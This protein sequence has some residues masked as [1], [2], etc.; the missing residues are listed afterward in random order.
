MKNTLLFILFILSVVCSPLSASE[1]EDYKN[2]SQLP[3]KE[4]YQKGIEM[5]NSQTDTALK[6]F[7]LAANKYSATLSSA[8]KFFCAQAYLKMGELHLDSYNFQ[9]AFENALKGVK[10]CEDNKIENLLP[11]FY[12]IIGNIYGIQRDFDLSIR[13]YKQGLELARKYK[14]QEVE[15]RLLSNLSLSYTN[16]ENLETARHYQHLLESHPYRDSLTL[17]FIDFNNAFIHAIEG[18]Y[19]NAIAEFKTNLQ[20]STQRKL[21]PH[22]IA[23]LYGNIAQIYQLINQ[24]DSALH[25]MLLCEQFTRQH[26]L[27]NF[28]KDILRM[29]S[30]FYKQ[31]NNLKKANEYY[32]HY[33][34]LADSVENN[35]QYKQLKN[36]QIIYELD[37]NSQQINQ[38]A[39]EK[40]E[41]EQ[42]V[43]RQRRMIL[44]IGLGLIVAI[45]ITLIIYKQKKKLQATYL[46]LYKRNNAMIQS[47]I[48]LESFTDT[49]AESHSEESDEVPETS[50]VDEPSESNDTSRLK[51]DDQQRKELLAQIKHIMEETT[52]YCDC[53]FSLEKL[54]S[55]IG[56]NSKYVSQLINETYGK[57]FRTFINEYRIK[58]ACLRLDNTEEYGNYTVQAIGE[59]VGYKS[60][61]NFTEIFKKHTGLTPAIYQKIAKSENGKNAI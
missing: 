3:I 11:Q 26:R 48:P 50:Q 43:V 47:E 49:P 38:L 57:N 31:Q 21:A 34:Q 40:Q 24:P 39:Q 42:Q 22:Y 45:C 54:A 9:Q 55:A 28:Q 5:E 14:L 23:S 19:T 61:G 1:I 30:E 35:L 8:D 15:S 6:Y 2:M 60:R 33:L 4:L 41:K 10:I 18:K 32:T 17:Y 36:T 58:L 20:E 13:Y 46:E 27:S 53:D 44:F 16:I 37:K 56:T 12:K 52:D 59:S 51:I 29:L 25:Y 7:M